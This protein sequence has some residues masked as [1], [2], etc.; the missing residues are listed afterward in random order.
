MR[1]L[2]PIHAVT[3]AAIT[4][5]WKSR[6]LETASFD[7]VDAI[8]DAL[9]AVGFDLQAIQLPVEGQARRRV[10]S[11]VSQ[12]TCGLLGLK[13]RIVFNAIT[14]R[15][16]EDIPERAILVEQ[17]RR[18]CVVADSLTGLPRDSSTA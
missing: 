7:F 18:L 3:L 8:A 15:G 14:D 17:I 10:A 4:S 5:V 12:T 9:Q 6:E 1:D 16:S 11:Y 13:V 2:F